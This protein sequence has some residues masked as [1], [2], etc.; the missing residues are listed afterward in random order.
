M[1]RHTGIWRGAALLAVVMATVLAMALGAPSRA[2]AASASAGSCTTAVQRPAFQG[3]AVLLFRGCPVAGAP[4]TADC[5]GLTA[6]RW[7]GAAWQRVDL[8]E[9]NYAFPTVYA[10]PFGSGWSWIWTQ[11]T[12][13]LAVGSHAVQVDGVVSG[14]H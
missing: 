10:Y 7:G 13:W 2:Q 1:Q 4:Q 6:Y 14:S 11:R 9:C 8:N 3:W 12:G 5:R